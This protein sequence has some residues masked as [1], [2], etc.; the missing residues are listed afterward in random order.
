MRK[1]PPASEDAS[2]RRVLLVDGMEVFRAGLAQVLAS[3]CQL[4]VCAST[5]DFDEVPNLIERHRPHVMIVEPFRKNGDGLFWIKDMRGRYPETKILV[6]SLNPEGTYAERI[7]RAGASGYWMKDG[8]PEKLCEAIEAV[9][10]GEIWV[11]PRVGIQAIEKLINGFR[12]NGDSLVEL[13]DRELAVF[14][15]IAA[16]HGTGRIA[17]ELGISRKTV[18]THYAHIKEKLGYYN[19]VALRR[20]ARESLGKACN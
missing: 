2:R 19:A 7:L 11:S 6:A 16:E 1:S 9:L 10:N 17:K 4:L 15:F 3:L 5:G 12:R 13:T 20:G 8:S 18:E 14:A